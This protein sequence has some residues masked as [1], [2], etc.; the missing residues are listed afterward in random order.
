MGAVP[1]DEARRAEIPGGDS[2]D[3]FKSMK[4]LVAS[5]SAS[6]DNANSKAKFSKKGDPTVDG[7]A[8]GDLEPASRDLE[9]AS[10]DLDSFP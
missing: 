5:D 3:D 2:N 6:D 7:D 8:E 9:P 1:S 4:S 10:R